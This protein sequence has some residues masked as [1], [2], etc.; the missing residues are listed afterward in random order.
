M[1]RV[2][3]NCP[4]GCGERLFLGDGGHVTCSG[5]ECP[6]P[7]AVDQVLAEA[8]TEHIVE[9]TEVGFSVQHPLRERLDGDL[10]HCPLHSYI[11]A[12]SGPPAR[13]GRYRAVLHGDGEQK[14][15]RFSEV[16]A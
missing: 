13:P 15:W 10:F 7:V 2:Q 6:N 11:K 4:M 16:I 8:E 1:E 9:F 14:A 5:L 12:L 3:G